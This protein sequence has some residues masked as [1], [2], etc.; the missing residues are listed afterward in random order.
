MVEYIER[1]AAIE[2]VCEVCNK[3]VLGDRCEWRNCSFIKML[4]SISAAD[5]R[6]VVRGQGKDAMW[7]ENNAEKTD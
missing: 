2:A 1:E 6:P 3:T 5:V 7:E 4:R